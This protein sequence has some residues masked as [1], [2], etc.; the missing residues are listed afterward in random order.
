MTI[1]Y[2]GSMGNA[3]GKSYGMNIHSKSKVK[4]W[5]EMNINVYR[6]NR[7]LQVRSFL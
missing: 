7:K 4:P 3:L 1:N 5:A 6:S 2:G